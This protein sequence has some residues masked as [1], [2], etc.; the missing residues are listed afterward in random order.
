MGSTHD[1]TNQVPPLIDYDA[2][3]IDVALQE[4]VQRIAGDEAADSLSTLGLRVGDPD[5]QRW[6]VRGQRQPANPANPRPLTG[7]GSTRSTSTRPG[8]HCMKVAV[9]EGL[10]GAP[11]A[12]TA[13]GAHVR[14]AAGFYVWSQ[15]EA[16]HGCPISMT[17][18]VVPALR[19]Q[20][21]LA[22][23]FEPGLTATTYDPGLRAPATQ[24]R[25]AGRHG[26]D[27]ETGRLG[28][29]G[30]HDHGDRR[31]RRHLS[32]HR[33]QVVLLSADE[34]SVPGAGADP[35]RGTVVFPRAAGRDP[36]ANA[37]RFACSG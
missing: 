28:R 2:A 25:V 18:S 1:V 9:G 31:R 13:P 26:H 6:A 5:V 36:T 29:A 15:A 3:T 17:Y 11:W 7:T 19:R 33:T 30:Q 12:S 14:R 20:P 35:V 8:T 10:A 16:G 22:R 24:G 27:R 37:T 21:E 4:N 23:V 32:A 34:R